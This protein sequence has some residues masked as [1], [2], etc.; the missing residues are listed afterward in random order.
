[1]LRD[2]GLD[3]G[4]GLDVARVDPDPVC[5]LDGSSAGSLNDRREIVEVELPLRAPDLSSRCRCMSS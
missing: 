1:M 5:G 3:A 4:V 2:P